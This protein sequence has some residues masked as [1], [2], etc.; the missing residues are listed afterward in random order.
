MLRILSSLVALASPALLAAQSGSF[1]LAFHGQKVGTASY[2]IAPAKSGFTSE[3]TIRVTTQGIHYA[4]S[5]NELLGADRQLRHADLSAVVNEQ[6]V[7]VVAEA[8][9]ATLHM[10]I[11]AGGR[12]TSTDLASHPL[13]V[14]LPDFDPGAF[15]ELLQQAA[16]H[17][18]RDLWAVLPRQT[19][20]IE[21]IE[22]ATYP[23][24][25][26]TLDGHD[27]I[28]HHLTATIAGAR[29]D[30]FSGP[31]NQLLQ[32]ELPQQGFA[33]I[34]TGFV[35]TPPTRPIAAPRTDEDG[36]TPQP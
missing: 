11:S 2:R 31:G 20:L 6:A 32:A 26:G 9:A 27:L 1:Q 3:S 28:V 23:D 34:R 25:K 19:G 14:L 30:L 8:E 18:N 12:T 7:H 29:A 15:E 13:A 35:L 17:N 10:K 36:T 33:L 4:L 24:E 21:A 16:A 22:L 5:K